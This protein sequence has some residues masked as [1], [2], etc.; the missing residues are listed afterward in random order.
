MALE[1][2]W[3]R[4]DAPYMPVATAGLL[5]VLS[6]QEPG[7]T[8]AWSP[9][10]LGP[11]LRVQTS[12]SAAEVGEAIAAAPW[13]DLQ[14]I[15]WPGGGPK[16]G[17][18]STL[19]AAEDPA[20][21]L[22]DMV[23][24]LVPLRSANATPPELLLLR[25]V[26]TDGA[27]NANGVPLRSRLLRGVK[28]DLSGVGKPPKVSGRLLVE[29]LSS[30]PAFRRGSS[31]LGLGFV[32]EVQTFG[33]TTGPEPSSVGS[34]SLLLYL[35][36]WRGIMALPPVAVAR[37][38]QRSVGGP[39]V[40]EPDVLSWPRWSIEAD[41]ACLRSLFVFPSLHDETPPSAALRARGIDSV[42]RSKAVKISKTVDVFRW[43][44]QVM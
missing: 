19:E 25:T 42:Y 18:S 34:Y 5:A 23:T 41:L 40:T 9:G 4:P 13:P 14:R 22:R 35:L 31:G 33:G 8:A 29:E 26:L 24:T 6:D 28:A 15:A 30:G 3:M 16:Q 21:A 12:R 2:T 36:L 38:R 20:Q 44:R 10:P 37:G 1:L 17:L 27:L 7:V 11:V 43:G 39:L 32:P